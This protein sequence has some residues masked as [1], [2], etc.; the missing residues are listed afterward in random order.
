MTAEERFKK[1]YESGDTPW[2]IGKPDFNLIQTVTTMARP[3]PDCILHQQQSCAHMPPQKPA[4]QPGDEYLFHKKQ[5]TRIGGATPC[6][7]L[8]STGT[9]TINSGK[10]RPL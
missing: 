5:T 2:G 10:T 1:R 3:N 7:S 8:T 4:Q 9:R 6:Q